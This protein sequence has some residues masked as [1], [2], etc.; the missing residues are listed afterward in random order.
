MT[1]ANPRRVL[2]LAL[3]CLLCNST[4]QAATVVVNNTNAAGVGFNATTPVAAVTGNP[5]TTVGAQRLATFQAAANAWGAM[6]VSAVPIVVDAQM[7]SLSCSANSATLGSAGATTSY[8]SF[9]GA[10]L[11]DVWYAS[12]L[13]NALAGLDLNANIPDISANFNQNIGTAGCLTGVPW[14]YVI[15][16]SAPPGTISFFDTV[17]HEIGHGLGFF[18]LV[19]KTSGALPNGLPDAYTRFMLDETPTPTLWTALNNAG[20]VASFTDNGNLTWSGSSVTSV[21]GLLSAGQHASGRVRLYAPTVLASGSSLSHWDTTLTP[22]EIMEFSLQASNRKRLTNHLM[23]DLGWKTM[24]ALAVTN[25]DG[26]PSTT[27]G[28]ATSYTMTLTNN[29]PGDIT[30]VNATVQ[31]AL[32][33]ALTDVTWTCGGSAGASCAP[34]NGSGSINA[35]VTVPLAGVITFTV[36]AT[37][38]AGFSGTLSNTVS[39]GMP[40]NVQN[41]FSSS[42]TDQTT[43]TSGLPT[44]GITVSAISGP[45]S[46]AGGTATFTVV[47]NTQPTANVTIG[48]SSND[49]SEGAVSPASLVF[50]NSNWNSSRLVTVTGMNDD[51]DDGDVVFSIVTAAASSSDGKYNGLN[52]ADVSVTN[53]DDEGELVFFNDFE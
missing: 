9:P 32:P 1:N 49:A 15:G 5:A 4:V 45:T 25:S 3:C 46:E 21:A 47:L 24:L 7:T 35:T 52:A 13:A 22:N 42:A 39:V 50:T 17:I 14:S 40:S 27:P 19:N 12:A 26:Q 53:L 8:A 41:S 2:A 51:A 43:V 37:I 30:L 38:D 31:D 28:S 29:G 44:D 33:A 23:Q 34:A 11:D 16:V 36:N 6:L 18:T 20:R 10:P 48:L